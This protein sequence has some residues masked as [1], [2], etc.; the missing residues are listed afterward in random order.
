MLPYLIRSDQ[1]GGNVSLSGMLC[2]LVLLQDQISLKPWGFALKPEVAVQHCG[3]A[4][5]TS[6]WCQHS[7]FEG[8]ILLHFG[9]SKKTAPR[10]IFKGKWGPELVTPQHMP[11][12]EFLSKSSLLHNLFPVYSSSQN[13]PVTQI[14]STFLLPFSLNDFSHLWIPDSLL[15]FFFLPSCFLS[16]L[17]PAVRHRNVARILLRSTV[18]GNYTLV[19]QLLLLW[20]DRC[21]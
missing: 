8:G 3:H 12:S 15:L 5:V 21:F 11:I 17:S 6:A 1:H 4:E 2:S 7:V 14:H 19:I 16:I 13:S 20:H 10:V 18:C 9:W